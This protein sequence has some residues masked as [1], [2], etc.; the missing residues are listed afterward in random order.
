MLLS[1]QLSPLFSGG[2]SPPS[3]TGQ[4]LL[5]TSYYVKILLSSLF[6]SL[7]GGIGIGTIVVQLT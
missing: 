4:T 7:F 5:C 3:L 2:N 6:V 1:L